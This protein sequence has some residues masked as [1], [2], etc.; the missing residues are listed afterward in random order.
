MSVGDGRRQPSVK[1][2]GVIFG[3]LVVLVVLVIIGL[4]VGEPEPE[5]TTA[6]GA[7]STPTVEAAPTPTVETAAEAA[8]FT[9]PLPT[10][11][12]WR[13]FTPA[14]ISWIDEWM[15]KYINVEYAGAFSYAD[16][17]EMRYNM[18]TAMV[19]NDWDWDRFVQSGESLRLQGEFTSEDWL[20]MRDLASYLMYLVQ[21]PNMDAYYESRRA[22]E[23]TIPPMPTMWK[24]YCAH[25]L[26]KP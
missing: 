4:I 18:C 20:L 6:G 24:A 21:Q 8:A 11:L 2:G 19:G 5:A 13:E 23:T 25:N 1:W 10:A 26:F 12:S 22:G 14:Q 3:V 15:D 9:A 7:M 17:A 16:D